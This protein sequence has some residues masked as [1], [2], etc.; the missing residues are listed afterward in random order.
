ML[1][2]ALTRAILA[3]SEA[4]VSAL[5][6]RPDTQS[7][8]GTSCFSLNKGKHIAKTLRLVTSQPVFGS[9]LCLQ[10]HHMG[11]LTVAQRWLLFAPNA[12]GHSSF[13]LPLAVFLLYASCSIPSFSILASYLRDLLGI[14]HNYL[15]H[16]LS[17]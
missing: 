13:S 16:F 17:H 2:S 4:L 7:L 1:W 6:Q 5:A 12:W 11:L 15:T 10:Y 9:T 8:L 14:L 3:A